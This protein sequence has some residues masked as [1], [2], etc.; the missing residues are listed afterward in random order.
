MT[1]AY[2][3]GATTTTMFT[4]TEVFANTE[5]SNCAMT[6]C[7]LYDSDCSTALP[8]TLSPYI[9]LSGG[10]AI[11]ISQ[12]STAGYALT[13]FC[14]SC[15]NG[16]QTVEKT[17]SAKQ[18]KDCSTSTLTDVVSDVSIDYGSSSSMLALSGYA[19]ASNFFTYTDAA[20]CGALTCE[21]KATG[22]SD[23]WADTTDV[24]MDASTYAV[25]AKQ[26]VGAGQVK[27]M[28]VKCSNTN[29]LATG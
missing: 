5:P 15:T 18:T 12:T 24:D 27:T 20:D 3:S 17:I 4:N 23:A 10:N 13:L 2:D 8:G 9:T 1:Y 6:S 28:C 21:L 7:T 19:D 11:M 25:S 22:C 14:I 16:A 26:N 29:D